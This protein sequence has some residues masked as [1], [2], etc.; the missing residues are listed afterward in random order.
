[1]KDEEHK[2]LAL[3]SLYDWYLMPDEEVKELVDKMREELKGVNII[4][5]NTSQ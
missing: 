4:L 1:M 5:K 2:A 3:N